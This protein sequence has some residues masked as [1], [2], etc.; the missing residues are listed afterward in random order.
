MKALYFCDEPFESTPEEELEQL[1]RE[2]EY[3]GV[4]VMADITVTTMPPFARFPDPVNYDILFFDW[5]GMSLGNSILDHFCREILREAED[6]PSRIYVLVSRMTME[7]ML[8]AMESMSSRLPNLFLTIK[9]F[10]ASAWVKGNKGENKG[11]TTPAGRP[12]L[13]SPGR[14]I[15]NNTKRLAREAQELARKGLP[16]E[17]DRERLLDLVRRI[18]A[19][20]N[21]NI[22]YPGRRRHK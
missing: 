18:E 13:K 21:S 5:G 12:T 14:G 2:L 15:L 7:A 8:D 9:D 3:E 1:K 4:E 22:E 20:I 19:G 17:K 6:Y 11:K 16:R 10:A